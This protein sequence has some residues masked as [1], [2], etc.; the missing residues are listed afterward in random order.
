MFF[1]PFQNTDEQLD[2][3]VALEQ[4]SQANGSDEWLPGLNE[5]FSHTDDLKDCKYFQNLILLFFI[6]TY[7]LPG[8]CKWVCWSSFNFF[9][10]LCTVDLFF[11]L[12]TFFK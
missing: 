12:I 5:A 9:F 11:F 2:L 7:C 10:C 4:A 6:W 3:E 1:F 8:T